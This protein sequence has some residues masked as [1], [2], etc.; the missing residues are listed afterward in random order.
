MRAFVSRWSAKHVSVTCDDVVGGQLAAA[1]L[2]STG[3][4]RF[5]VI[6]GAQ[7]ASTTRDRVQGFLAVLEGHGIGRTDVD[8]FYT[9]FD[10][11]AGQRAVDEIIAGPTRPDAIF[12]VNDFA[13]IGAIGALQTLGTS[14]PDDIAVIGYNDTPIAQAVHLTTVR[15]PMVEMGRLGFEKLALLI[16]KKEVLSERL[17]PAFIVRLTA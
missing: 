12:A 5:A 6:A 8:L 7:H 1:H 10:A 3:R 17:Q 16:E 14:V 4:K 13:A 2:L 9:G 15:S 11:P